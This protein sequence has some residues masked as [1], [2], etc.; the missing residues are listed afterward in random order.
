MDSPTRRTRRID[1]VTREEGVV[2]VIIVPSV[3]PVVGI[4]GKTEYVVKLLNVNEDVAE[5]NTVKKQ[6]HLHAMEGDF[7][8][9]STLVEWGAVFDHLSTISPHPFHAFDGKAQVNKKFVVGYEKNMLGWITLHLSTGKKLQV[10]R[11]NTTSIK[12]MLKEIGL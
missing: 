11:T 5:I 12:E 4:D 1:E 2:G 3:R 7:T 10:S 9:P 6:P 8:L